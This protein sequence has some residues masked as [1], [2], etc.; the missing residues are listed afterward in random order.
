MM[1]S[2]PP[3]STLPTALDA[4]AS[5]W[6][7]AVE[8][9][10]RDFGIGG[11]LVE[12]PFSGTPQRIELM[13]AGHRLG[14]TYA[15]AARPTDGQM[16]ERADFIFLWTQVDAGA[17]A[18]LDDV[19][20][21]TPIDFVL[22]SAEAGLT[23]TAAR[24]PRLAD[25]R[26]HLAKADLDR[27]RERFPLLHDYSEIAESGLFDADFY[28]QD[29]DLVPVRDGDLLRHYLTEGEAEGARPNRFFDPT[30][31]LKA[32]GA[33]EGGA[34]RHYLRS[35][36]AAGFRPS[37]IFEPEWYAA[38]YG[39]DLSEA[40]ALAHYLRHRA[41]NEV[42][43]NRYFDPAYYL[44]EN[45]DVRKAG[46][47]AFEHWYDWGIPEGRKG[48]AEFDP[49]YVTRRYLGQGLGRNPLDAF[50]DVG[51]ELGWN[52]VMGRDAPSL[53]REIAENSA[54]GPLFETLSPPEA[55]EW[56]AKVLA[57]HLP[58]FHAIPEND[59]W[60]GEGFT[61]WR[62]LARGMP[63]FRGHYQPR[64]P[65]DFGFYDLTDGVTLQKQVELAAAMG[66]HGFCFYYYNFNGHRLLETP[67]DAFV[68]DPDIEFPF[69]LMWAN[70]NWTRRWDGMED[71]VLI[72][73]DYAPEESAALIA[74]IAR[75]MERPNYIRI[76]DRPVFFIYRADIIPDC[77]ATLAH[78]RDLF[79]NEHGLDPIIA[80]AQ[81]FGVTDPR[82]D[83]F[84]GA[85]EFPPHKLG[86]HL[87]WINSE[88]EFHD[89][90]FTGNVRS[91]PQAVD[92][93]LADLPG[94]YP[95]IKTAFPMWD[96]DARRQ[97]T[98]MCFHGSTPEEF[99]RWVAGLTEIAQRQP[100]FGEPL[101]C[102]NA[103]NEWCE[104]AYLEP[105]CH[106][107]HAY[108]N[109]LARAV[110][111][112]RPAVNVSRIVLVG[113]DAF[114]SGAQQLLLNLGRVLKRRF[115]I[116][117][118][119][120]LMGEG[121][122]LGEY[123]AIGPTHVVRDTP[124]KWKALGRHLAKL[125]AQGY[126]AVITNTV[127][128]GAAAGVLADLGFEVCS[129]IHELPTIVR[130][131]H[132]VAEYER[133]RDRAGLT[134]FPNRF[135]Q[136][137]VSA[138]FGAP[139]GR[140]LVRAQGKYKKVAVP[141]DARQKVREELGLP[142]FSRIVMNVGYGDFRKGIDVFIQV[143]AR[144]AGTHPNIHFVWVGDRDPAMGLWL[145]R[146][147]EARRLTNV[148]FVPFTREVGRYLGAADLFFLSSRED[149][150]PSVILEALACGLP[151]AAFDY[152]GGHVE[153]LD[154][155]ALGV[156][157]PF[158]DVEAS[159]RMIAARAYDPAQA[160][161]R[162][163]AYRKEFVEARFGFE[164]YAADLLANLSSAY[165]T[166]SVIV[167]NY[168]YA[169]Y[170]EARLGSI[171]DQAY[172]VFEI[173]VLDDASTDD[174]LS[175]V[176]SIGP[177]HRRTLHLHVNRTNSGNVF[178]QWKTGLD[179]ATG[180]YVWIAE[181]DDLADPDF[182]GRMVAHL[183]AAPDAGF[184]FCD[185]RAIDAEGGALYDSYKGYYAE[186]GDRG[187]DRDGVF[188]SAEFLRRFL[189]ERN[190]VLN[191]S[192]V[193]WR[194]DHLREI[195]DTLGEEAFSFSCA[196]DWRIYLESCRRGADVAYCAEALN[197]HRRHDDSVTHSLDRS[198]H[199]AEIERIH[200]LVLANL[201]DDAALA[202]AIRRHD[203]ELAEHWGV[204][205]REDA[206]TV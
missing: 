151:V 89:P 3:L 52:P 56:R 66:V 17:L 8:T 137:E 61:E 165:R 47:D 109:A 118:Q 76:G 138:A 39:L 113:H 206:E 51:R 128:S 153:M 119:F 201:P 57:F 75:Y 196:G 80:M 97:G 81:T 50:M 1:T 49:A 136:G 13:C 36:E 171:L 177:K 64:I 189:G 193:L 164:D 22:A 12:R 115:G 146:E 37:V 133:I 21:N 197:V 186:R 166:V 198:R 106:F 144:L 62:N 65:R 187:L 205:P 42:S 122:L 190:L 74:D 123:S 121:A 155:P 59:E 72:R 203:E 149:P 199:F 157:M 104:G 6:A 143:A 96:N 129:L 100:F 178:R 18:A 139:R 77:A 148:H 88:L 69:C 110:A 86:T 85:I 176:E 40:N 120:V 180:E 159:A 98:G 30:F 170:L 161:P 185:S 116:E 35:G 111:L 154:D 172:P 93:S 179:R 90:G 10:S 38:T 78:W 103:W 45:A 63:R 134:V 202:E 183:S 127:F 15:I 24:A 167:P 125:K 79:R 181:A 29:R 44:G 11:W 194:A 43:P 94:E 92:L 101:V 67:L 54:P 124:A 191:A 34:L 87:P 140:Q 163:M 126:E 84:D 26:K 16:V 145:Q 108:V 2:T 28:R 55:A 71:E 188:E 162:R 102:I 95:L 25:L 53:H 182:L 27:L 33:A 7:G 31:Y 135:V 175:V 41:G 20:P 99:R 173:I 83:G 4:T 150:F 168:N 156:L 58:Q 192:A 169:R 174:S 117:V 204:R 105:D 73:Q 70:E 68:E 23:V 130:E 60:W 131:R 132:G 46:V 114:P 158:M 32:G 195:F 152:G 14:S 5:G 48:S 160:A 9:V 91:Y 112:T 19:E 147:I 200:D 141:P 184:A 107:G 82:P 142:A